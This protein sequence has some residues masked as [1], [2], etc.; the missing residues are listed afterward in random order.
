MRGQG[1]NDPHGLAG[2]AASTPCRVIPNYRHLGPEYC[3]P[4]QWDRASGSGEYLRPHLR[5][6]S[7]RRHAHLYAEQ[8]FYFSP[9]AKDSRSDSAR[10]DCPGLRRGTSQ[11]IA[12]NR[13]RLRRSA[14]RFKC[15]EIVINCRKLRGADRIK[16]SVITFRP[17]FTG[18]SGR[19]IPK[20]WLYGWLKLEKL[21]RLTGVEPVTSC[22]GGRP[23]RQISTFA[24]I[25]PC[26]DLFI[27][28]R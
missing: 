2:F 9:Y 10:R 22:S 6:P 7:R 13:Q 16:R 26:V 25:R 15:K 14:F 11:S 4:L 17:L 8:I 18:P 27:P 5:L 23:W 3:A 19:S 21:V 28:I 20:S 24:A 12:I 1:R